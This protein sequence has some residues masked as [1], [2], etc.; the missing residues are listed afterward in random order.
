MFPK[1]ECD[2][3]SHSRLFGSRW[4]ITPFWLSGSLRPFWYSLSVYFCHLFLI[5]SASLRYII[6]LSF[7]VLI[8][9]RN[10]PLV[11]LTFLK[12]SLV[13]PILLFPSISLHCSLKKAFLSLLAILWNFAFRWVY[14]S[15]SLLPF[16]SLL[17]ST[18]CK[19]SSDSSFALLHLFGG[20][21]LV[22][23]FSTML[24]TSVLC[25]SALCLSDPILWIYLSVSL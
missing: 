8:F 12:R 23:T 21:V 17:F 9:A 22:S 25:S 15:F 19:A 6:L 11:S 2:L 3:M 5:A 13:F 20:M 7:V 10:V 14:L 4:V 1:Q 18:I 16:I 24:Q